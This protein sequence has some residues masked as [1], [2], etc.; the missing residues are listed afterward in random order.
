MNTQKLLT[1][2]RHLLLGAPLLLPGF[3]PLPLAAQ[4]TNVTFNTGASRL[5][6]TTPGDPCIV[7]VDYAPTN[8]A[9]STSITSGSTIANPAS[10]TYNA[11]KTRAT[12]TVAPKANKSGT[13]T[14]RIDSSVGTFS[15]T[16]SYTLVFAPYLP[17]ISNIANK[18]L[19]ED[20]SL[21][22]SFTVSDADTDLADLDTWAES[23]N[24]A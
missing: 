9:F 24:P 17:E 10:T 20:G 4:T 3:L 19:N 14:L 11:T 6:T 18:S 1:S 21:A 15:R 12:F 8:M 16:D 7:V 22:V 2:A 5:I 23:S 13:A